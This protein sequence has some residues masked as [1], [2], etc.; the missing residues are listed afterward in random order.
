[1]KRPLILTSLAILMIALA[2]CS[3]D[4]VKEVNQG[5]AIGFRPY[6]STRGLDISWL[7]DLNEFYVTAYKE[8]DTLYFKDVAFRPRPTIGPKARHS[9]SMLRPQVPNRWE[10]QH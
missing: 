10:M 1:M 5:K 6:I 8:G 2:S 4:E 7:S 3:M 9:P